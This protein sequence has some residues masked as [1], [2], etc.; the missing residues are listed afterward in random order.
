MNLFK[1]N[2]SLWVLY[3]DLVCGLTHAANQFHLLPILR[4]PFGK[5]FLPSHYI[6]WMLTTPVMVYIL[7]HISECSSRDVGKL[8][9]I[10]MTTKVCGLLSLIRM[11]LNVNALFGL[12]AFACFF[13]EMRQL[14]GM[15]HEA[16]QSMLCDRTERASK[17]M[18]RA[19]EALSFQVIWIWLVLDLIR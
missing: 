7:S 11:P 1:R 6:E 2:L 17:V 8:M 3:I 4:D 14:V 5:V 19:I 10:D 13:H 18:F 12:V 9:V 15:F 16:V